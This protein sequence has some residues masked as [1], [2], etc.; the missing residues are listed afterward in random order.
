MPEQFV[1]RSQD[2]AARQ[3]FYVPEVS[4]PA[5]AT[6]QWLCFRFRSAGMQRHSAASHFAIALRAE[7]GFDADGQPISIS[8]RGITWGDTS[9]AWAPPDNAF[10]VA[11][12]FGGARGAQVESFWAGG[13][14]LYRQARLLDQGLVDGTNY[15]VHLHVSDERWVAFWVLDDAGRPIDPA[16]HACVQDRAEHPVAPDR[17]GIVIA[18]GRAPRETG[19]WQAE[20]SELEWGWF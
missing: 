9:Q 12:G 3:Y 15:H 7:L 2:D 1:F 13:N 6:T 4:R 5:G 20:F 10:A 11:P 14:F 8:G 16:G 18:L 17:T 19:P